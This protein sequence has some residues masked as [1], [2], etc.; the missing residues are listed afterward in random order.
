MDWRI[1]T[2]YDKALKFAHRVRRLGFIVDVEPTGTISAP[3]WTVY[4]YPGVANDD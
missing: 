1:F 3:E 2:E 4:V